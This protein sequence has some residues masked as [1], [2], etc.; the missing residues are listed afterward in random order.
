MVVGMFEPICR[1]LFVHEALLICRWLHWRRFPLLYMARKLII[2]RVCFVP[3]MHSLWAV[4]V[5]RL[6]NSLV[7]NWSQSV[8]EGGTHIG[9]SNDL[10]TKAGMPS[11]VSRRLL[12]PFPRLLKVLVA[13]E[14]TWL[15]TT[16]LFLSDIMNIGL[17][18][19]CW[20]SAFDR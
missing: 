6:R 18:S 16:R 14:R 9:Y 10:Y 13:E 3:R 2:Q 1:L 17:I 4:A 20:N 5:K 19:C 7:S 12:G 15:K 8:N 11:K